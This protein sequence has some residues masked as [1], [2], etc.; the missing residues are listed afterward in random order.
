[1]KVSILATVG[2][3][4]GFVVGFGIGQSTRNA[5]QSNISSDYSGGKLQIT[6]DVANAVRQGVKDYF[7]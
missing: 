2:L 6:V 3:V 5:A 7:S 4:A 1:M